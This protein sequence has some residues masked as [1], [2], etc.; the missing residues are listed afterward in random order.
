MNPLLSVIVP[1][2]NTSFYLKRC[3]ESICKQSFVQLEIICVDDGSTDNSLE[4]LEQISKNEP[5]IRIIRRAH[6][7]LVEARKAGLSEAKGDYVTYVDSDDWIESS[8]YEEMVRS[9]KESGAD[10]ITSGIIRDY[11]SF[12]RDDPEKAEPGLYDGERLKI[13]KSQLIDTK[14]AFRFNVM[15]SLC[16]KLFRRE[17]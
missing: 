4:I 12:T 6:N 3:I 16:I 7:G 15:P 1:V 17:L 5:R 2:Y 13:L 8:M 9:A 10:I 14:E 11:G